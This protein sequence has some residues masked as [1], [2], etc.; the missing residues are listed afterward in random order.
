VAKEGLQVESLRRLQ[1]TR[2]APRTFA[3]RV[4][5]T[6]KALPVEFFYDIVVVSHGRAVAALGVLGLG[7]PVPDRDR[8]GFARLLSERMVRALGRPTGPSA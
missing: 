2:V 3:V 5:L 8:T 7:A 1:V 4:V 6:G